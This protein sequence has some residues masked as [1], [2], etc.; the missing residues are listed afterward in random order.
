M[1]A[2]FVTSCSTQTILKLI[3]QLVFHLISILLCLLLPLRQDQ[4]LS[5]TCTHCCTKDDKEN[6]LC[7]HHMERCCFLRRY[8]RCLDLLPSYLW[9]LDWQRPLWKPQDC[10]H[11]RILDLH[12]RH[13]Y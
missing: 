12:H 11:S 1:Y 4:H 5:L 13:R 2:L 3:V 6:M 8:R 9:L 7:R 10:E